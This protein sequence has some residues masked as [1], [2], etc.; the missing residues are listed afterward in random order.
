MKITK[1]LLKSL[2]CCD[3]GIYK[4]INTPELHDIDDNINSIII[5]NK[6]Q[7]FDDFVYFL[8]KIKK[9]IVDSIKYKN[10][11]GYWQEYTYDDKGNK[12]KYED[13]TGYW[14]EYTYDDKGNKIKY[15]NSDGFWEKSTYDDKG[16]KIK[17][18]NSIGAW[19][20]Y[21]YD[22]KGNKIKYENSTGYWKK[23]TYD[24]NNIEFVKD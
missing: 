23:Y 3:D 15:K 6:S 21:T 22:D 4:F 2:R 18:E 5:K 24:M 14:Q 12:I 16:N 7:T 20:K 1:R 11:D 13:S 19:E 9:H 17:F 10:S 8:D